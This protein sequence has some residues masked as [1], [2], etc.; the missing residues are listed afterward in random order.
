M[1]RSKFDPKFK[2]GAHVDGIIGSTGTK[3]IDHVT[4]QMRYLSINHSVMGHAITLSTP[5]H[6][7]DVISVHLS[8]Q[9]RNP[10]P[11]KNR[12]KGRNNK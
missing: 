4:H 2:P 12:R 6:S 1:P 5:T 8:D 7:V 11:K 3:V 10:K 9:K